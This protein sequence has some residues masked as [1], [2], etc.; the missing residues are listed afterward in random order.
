MKLFARFTPVA[1]FALLF[2]FNSISGA[3]DDLKS[4]VSPLPSKK[5]L[6]V[7]TVEAVPGKQPESGPAVGRVELTISEGE[8]AKH[9][10]NLW[11]GTTD[12]A[13]EAI[14]VQSIQIAESRTA[15]AQKRFFIRASKGGY[16]GTTRPI[17]PGAVEEIVALS[18]WVPWMVRAIDADT[19]KP[20][21]TF[22]VMNRMLANLSTHYGPTTARNGEALAGFFSEKYIQ[23]RQLTIEADGYETFQIALTP[24]LGA[25]NTYELK[26]KPGTP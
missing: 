25:T 2:S 7:R 4:P 14:W 8:D 24:T 12:E 10:K 15:T 11:T 26:R 22:T 6:K 1:M 19:K 20:I 13:G 23:P 17:D 21:P 9:A 3:A 5:P 16:Q 18:K